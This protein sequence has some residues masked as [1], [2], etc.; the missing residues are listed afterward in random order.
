MFHTLNKASLKPVP[1]KLKASATLPVCCPLCRYH[2]TDRPCVPACPA[3]KSAPVAYT[4][5]AR[6]PQQ[7]SL[8]LRESQAALNTY[9]T[10]YQKDDGDPELQQLEQQRFGTPT[11]ALI[12]SAY[13][14]CGIAPIRLCYC[15]IIGHLYFSASGRQLDF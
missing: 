5:T 7:R 4:P 11:I 13:A 3:K 1:T 14:F 2:H 6:I 10:L 9:A 12:F 8:S 15:S